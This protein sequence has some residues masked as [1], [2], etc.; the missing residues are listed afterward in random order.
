MNLTEKEYRQILSKLR[1]RLNIVEK[2]ITTE[3]M[4]KLT[5]F[6]CQVKL[7]LNIEIYSI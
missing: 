7:W 6:Q 2:H 5:I 4:R 3:N 1:D